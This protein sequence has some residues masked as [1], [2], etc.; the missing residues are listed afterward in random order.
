MCVRARL[1]KQ[2]C[3]TRVCHFGV[4]RVKLPV[5]PLTGSSARITR[6]S[7]AISSRLSGL[8]SLVES[9]SDLK[10]AVNVEV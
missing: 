3:S 1:Q 8:S 5:L 2:A 7:A 6:F 10:Q 9:I 4:S